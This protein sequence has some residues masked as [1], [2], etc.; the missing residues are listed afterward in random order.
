MLRLPF[1]WGDV[2]V[3]LSR[4]AFRFCEPKT[5]FDLPGLTHLSRDQKIGKK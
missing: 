4:V 2:R 5:D 1:R 3:G